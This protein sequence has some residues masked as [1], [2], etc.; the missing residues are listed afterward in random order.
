LPTSLLVESAR[1]SSRSSGGAVTSS[2]R[3]ALIA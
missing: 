2:E 1:S 3:S